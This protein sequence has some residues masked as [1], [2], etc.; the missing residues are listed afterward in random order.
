VGPVGSIVASGQ[1]GYW[2]TAANSIAANGEL[3]SRINVLADASANH[4][5]TPSSNSSPLVLTGGY[6]AQNPSVFPLIP[7]VDF[8]QA[9]GI[10]LR[11]QSA[12]ETPVTITGA[13]WSAGVATYT[14]SAAHTLAVGDKDVVSGITPSGYN[15]TFIV[16]YVGSPTTFS[17]P[18]AVN[19]GTWV[20]GP[21]SSS[22]ISN[23]ISQ[24][25]VLELIG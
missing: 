15:G 22:R 19:P 20:S 8:S 2:Q 5:A 21:G 6:Q 7:L 24:S 14:T 23:M 16:S 18:M 1:F 9:W 4:I 12:A 3:I 17:V 13:T 11:M 25:Y 10:A